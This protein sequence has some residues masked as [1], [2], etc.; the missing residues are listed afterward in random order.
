MSIR[1]TPVPLR[2]PDF[3]QR[4]RFLDD[5]CGVEFPETLM[6]GANP[7]AG[8]VRF[9]EYEA[10]VAAGHLRRRGTRIRLRGQAFD[11]LALL[12]ERAGQVVTR[13]ELQ[14][15]LWPGHVFVDFDNNL[16]TAVARLR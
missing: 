11:V 16:N 12:V 9:G 13:E 10:D 8:I 7:A 3:R 14:H 2:L 15:R 1:A 6:S 4:S 5:P